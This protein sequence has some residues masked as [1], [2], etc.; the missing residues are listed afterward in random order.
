MPRC[1]DVV[2]WGYADWTV[3]APLRSVMYAMRLYFLRFVFDKTRQ[4]EPR[5]RRLESKHTKCETR[6]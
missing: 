2:D 5:E 4:R 6:K 1:K 3:Q